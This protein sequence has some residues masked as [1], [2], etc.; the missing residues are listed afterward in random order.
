MARFSR[1]IFA[2]A[3]L[4]MASAAQG[5]TINVSA[6]VWGS[7]RDAGRDGSFE[8]ISSTT[9][10]L[11]NSNQNQS[12]V[13][14]GLWEFDL[15]ELPLGTILG[16]NLELILVSS[17]LEGAPFDVF[18]H[19]GNGTIETADATAGSLLAGGLIAG[20]S[21]IFDVT[22]FILGPS[23]QAAG[24]AGFMARFSVETGPGTL[25]KQFQDPDAFFGNASPFLVVEFVPVPVPATVWLFGSAL[26]LLGW[27]RRKAA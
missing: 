17:T 15:S 26:G 23:V 13:E 11:L 14:R 16:I 2:F 24:F 19:V 25:F 5:D 8:Q 27:M 9:D 3:V 12:F 21:T 6:S 20:G 18:G 10:I 7:A 22:A 4:L 1:T